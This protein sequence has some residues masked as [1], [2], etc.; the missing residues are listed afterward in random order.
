VGRQLLFRHKLRDL[1]P[2]NKGEARRS[3]PFRMNRRMT[4]T[5]RILF[6]P[7][8]KAKQN[9]T[10][11]KWQCRPLTGNWFG[12]QA[13]TSRFR[14]GVEK[15]S[16]HHLSQNEIGGDNLCSQVIKIWLLRS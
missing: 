1:N 6:H 10:A 5:C 13:G 9:Q 16:Y 3:M 4:S 12:K 2:S 7:E 8:S 11:I 14:I 15:S